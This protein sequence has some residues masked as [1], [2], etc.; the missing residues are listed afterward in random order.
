MKG[1]KEEGEPIEKCYRQ[2]GKKEEGGG[3]KG[4]GTK[5]KKRRSS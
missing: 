5:R 3:G 1:E 2:I 4:G